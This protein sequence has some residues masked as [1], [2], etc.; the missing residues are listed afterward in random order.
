V[1]R[2][3]AII[4]VLGLVAAGCS[5]TADASGPPEIVYGRDLCVEC[6]MLITESR[7]AAAYRANDETRRFDDIGNMIK[8]GLRTG[9]L[10]SDSDDA[11]VHDYR[12]DVW[13][14]ADDAFYVLAPG[15][16]TPM[17]WG[18]VAVETRERAAALA[19][20]REGEVLTWHDLFDFSYDDGKLTHD[21]D[22]EGPPP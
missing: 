20:E 13:I 18:L 6:G 11:W 14:S 9:E 19:T 7:F 16:V 8:Y 21:H 2:I 1:R 10:T 22:H 17:G 5:G 12:L 15:M 3:A 4:V